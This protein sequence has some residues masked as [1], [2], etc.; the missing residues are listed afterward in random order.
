M[1]GVANQLLAAIALGVGTTLIVKSGKAKYS[2]VT[3]LPMIFMF[4]TTL[5][6]AW[7]LSEMFLAKAA[8]AK[9]ASDVFN[10]RLDAGLVICMAVLAVVSLGDMI[11]RWIN[12]K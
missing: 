8:I 12:L 2:W 11:Y 9:A 7:Q 6:A 3:G 5:T 4:T 10:F 1:F